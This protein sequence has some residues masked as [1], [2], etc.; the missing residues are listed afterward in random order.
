MKNHYWLCKWIKEL[1]EN[2]AKPLTAL[3]CTSTW[4]WGRHLCKG[5]LG[6]RRHHCLGWYRVA[7]QCNR[8]RAEPALSEL[9][10]R[11]MKI[12]KKILKILAH[13]SL[14]VL[15]K[16]VLIKKKTECIRICCYSFQASS[17]KF[18]VKFAVVISQIF[19]KFSS[20]L[21]GRRRVLNC[22]LFTLSSRIHYM[23]SLWMPKFELELIHR[24]VC[25][26]R[27]HIE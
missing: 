19:H 22:Q 6:S 14:D 4:C 2:K 25:F 17:G 9:C 16:K 10:L 13:F 8:G 5:W 27:K 12:L 26:L 21:L 20:V 7:Q 24:S 18:F 23:I 11:P 3:K 15:I 1:S